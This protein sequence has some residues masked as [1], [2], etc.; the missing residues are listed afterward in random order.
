M[1]QMISNFT[2]EIKFILDQLV[3]WVKSFQT[4]SFLSIDYLKFV[5]LDQHERS[6]SSI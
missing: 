4:T 5:D 1:H 6:G 2:A 3:V